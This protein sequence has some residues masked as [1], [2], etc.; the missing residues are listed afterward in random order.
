MSNTE[1]SLDVF[2][3]R[4]NL[5]AVQKFA[6]GDYN[7]VAIPYKNI[8]NIS[9]SELFI[10]RLQ[11]YLFGCTENISVNISKDAMAYILSNSTIC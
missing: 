2:L 10:E 3:Q 7:Y 6:N 8:A 11:K 4:D 1:K 9:S 5:C